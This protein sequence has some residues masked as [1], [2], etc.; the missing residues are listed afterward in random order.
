VNNHCLSHC[1]TGFMILWAFIVSL[2]SYL[3]SL[4]RRPNSVGFS[5]PRSRLWHLIFLVPLLQTFPALPPPLRDGWPEYRLQDSRSACFHQS[6]ISPAHF[7]ARFPPALRSF[8]FGETKFSVGDQL[9][10]SPPL[11][12]CCWTAEVLTNISVGLLGNLLSWWQ[13]TSYS[14][15]TWRASRG[16]S[17]L[18]QPHFGSLGSLEGEFLTRTLWNESIK[19]D[20][21]YLL[22][23]GVERPVFAHAPTGSSDKPSRAEVGFAGLW[24]PR[25]TRAS[26]RDWGLLCQV[27][28]LQLLTFSEW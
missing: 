13:L 5:S 12:E 7:F 14:F 17:L 10:H 19:L 21:P 20:H 22:A 15:P 1:S 9:C 6:W 24:F 16:C 11:P 23:Y 28:L 27:L 18:S 8:S 25:C 2:L 3:F 26:L 4:L